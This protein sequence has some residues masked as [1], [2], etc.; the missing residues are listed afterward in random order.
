MIITATGV[1]C[2]C[3]RSPSFAVTGAGAQDYLYPPPSL[4]VGQPN[5][6]RTCASLVPWRDNSAC[7]T[8]IV[9]PPA[10][11]N[12]TE[13]SQHLPSKILM[14]DNNE[15]E[16]DK[17]ATMSVVTTASTAFQDNHGKRD[18]DKHCHE[19][20]SVAARHR[21]CNWKCSGAARGKRG[22]CD[23]GTVKTSAARQ[24][25]ARQ[26]GAPMWT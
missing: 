17:A 16:H 10:P 21:R 3:I 23:S 2:P 15:R 9:R 22:K 1:S 6:L 19:T 8:L 13:T 7:F 24:G 20:T 26:G 11:T 4:S 18:H 14:Q 12:E 25:Q 5:L